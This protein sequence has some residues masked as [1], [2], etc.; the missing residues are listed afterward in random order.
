M[1]SAYGHADESI[2]TT[3]RNWWSRAYRPVERGYREC[4]AMFHL[5]QDAPPLE[6]PTPTI[7]IAGIELPEG[8]AAVLAK[9]RAGLV[10]RPGGG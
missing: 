7:R 5:G 8:E 1:A 10:A 9:R 6:L 2:E 3:R 4:R